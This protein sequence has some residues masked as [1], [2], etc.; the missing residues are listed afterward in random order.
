VPDVLL[1][2]NHQ[3]IGQWRREASLARTFLKRPD[4]LLESPMTSEDL[5]FLKRLQQDIQ[6]IIEKHSTA[7]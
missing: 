5:R 1:S 2:G 6:A 7:S 3:A 4:L